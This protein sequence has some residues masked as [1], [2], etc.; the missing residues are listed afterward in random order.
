M[1]VVKLGGSLNTDPV[2]PE[3]LDLLAQLGGGRVTI[4]CGG[5][6][7]ADEVRRAQAHWQF[8]DLAAHN[9]AVLAMAQSAY[10]MRALKPGLRLASSQAEIR[11]VLHGGHTALWL[12]LGQRRDQVGADTNWDVSADSMALDLARQ[13]NAERL[14]IVKA[15]PIPPAANLADLSGAG[16]LD[17]RF[18]ALA[19][20]A[21]C[22]IDVIQGTELARMRSLL[23]GELRAAGS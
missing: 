13:L 19:S 10:L 14:V 6:V 5:G 20:G 7:F 22:A 18:A 17:R 16:I 11:H 3:W 12:P 1:W 4:V 15:C 9:M 8:D 21:A 23:L 2:L